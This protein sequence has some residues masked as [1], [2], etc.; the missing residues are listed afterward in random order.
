MLPYFDRNNKVAFI[1]GRAI[2]E[3]IQPR[4]LNLKGE[5]P[6]PWN[7]KILDGNP[8]VV[9]LCESVIDAL[10]LEEKGFSSV[11]IAGTSSFKPQWVRGFKNKK[12]FLAFDS[13][14]PGQDAAEKLSEWFKKEDIFVSSIQLPEGMD[15]NEWFNS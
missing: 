4:F 3:G 7:M 11:G 10:T 15:V 9:Y 5:I 2:E 12:V 13:D 1:Q 14:K 6:F 8:D